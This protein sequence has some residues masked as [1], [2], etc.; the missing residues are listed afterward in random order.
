ELVIGTVTSG[1]VAYDLPN[2][3]NAR[4]LWSTGR[5]SYARTGV[6]AALA[7]P[8]ADVIPPVVAITSPIPGATV[9]RTVTVTASASDD[10]GVA[11]VQFLLD[12]GALGAEDTT[13]PY[14]VA[15]DTT[16]TSNGSHTVT[17]R[18]RDA[19]GNTATSAA[20]V[21]TVSNTDT[22][23]PTVAITAPA[24]GATVSSTVTVTASASDNVGVAGVQFL[25]DGG[26][27]GAEDTTAPY[28][29]AWDTTTTSNGSHTVTARARD[30]A[31]NTA[32]SA[33]VTVTVANGAPPPATVTRFETTEPSVTFTRP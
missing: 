15:W 5:G 28:G 16:T 31:G 4:V 7:L 11:G 22:T 9:S 32:T 30:A 25:L 6:S 1:V 13:A 20:V 10:V 26:A 29:V 3:A 12:G 2:T 23:P 8:P 14:A 33:A 24:N 27:L 18:A 21:V 17:A 19:A